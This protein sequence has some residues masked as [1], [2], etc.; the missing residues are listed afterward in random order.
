MLLGFS[1][2][3][4]NYGEGNYGAG[5]YG[6]AS[7]SLSPP[8]GGSPGGGGGSSRSSSSNNIVEDIGDFFIDIVDTGDDE[9]DDFEIL[10]IENIKTIYIDKLDEREIVEIPL[11][12][13]DCIESF[14]LITRN[15]IQ[16][17]EISIE[18]YD[19]ESES[20]ESLCSISVKSEDIDSV[21]LENLRLR[22]S[23]KK[24]DLDLI[25]SKIEEIV[26]SS[27]D[28]ENNIVAV[29]IS[30]IYDEEN[31]EYLIIADSKSFGLFVV[32]KETIFSDECDSVW[33]C[34]DINMCS[35]P[36]PETLR[37]CTLISQYQSSVKPLSPEL[38]GLYIMAFVI[39]TIFV[40]FQVGFRISKKTTSIKPLIR[41]LMRNKNKLNL[42]ND[43]WEDFN[44]V[45]CVRCPKCGN[46]KATIDLS[47]ENFQMY[48]CNSCKYRWQKNNL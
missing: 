14:E 13:D 28:E 35:T 11:G 3:Y 23:V 20:V 18:N 40:A 45:V 6:V 9:D 47:D 29:E 8:S 5:S 16:N 32:A 7:I 21:D 30:Y 15:Q 24:S 39:V 38:I 44:P 22:F 1:L 41:K 26:V 37:E 34:T 33:A 36:G 19:T 17:V 25:N 4:A 43:N 46:E 2:A 27:R 31:E 12:E 42:K 10:A 48:E